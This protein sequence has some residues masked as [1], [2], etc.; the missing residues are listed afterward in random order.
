LSAVE[1]PQE[2]PTAGGG[3]SGVP[4]TLQGVAATGL[5]TLRARVEETHRRDALFEDPVGVRM[6]ERL[7][8]ASDAASIDWLTQAGVAL[9]TEIFDQAVRGFLRARPHAVVANLGAGFCTRFHRVDDGMVRWIDVDLPQVI[10]LKR[11]VLE[12][13]A[14]YRLVASSLTDPAWMDCVERH[15]GQAMLVVAEGVL[16]YLKERDVRVLFERLVARFS[17][18]EMVFDC[19][20]P[21]AVRLSGLL[22]SLARTGQRPAWGLASTRMLR[23]LHPDIHLLAGWSY[24]RHPDRLRWIRYVRRVPAV[25]RLMT[26][27]HVRLG[28]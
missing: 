26:T 23:V 6:L 21:L 20:S 16:A 11:E 10:A 19:V 24:D 25:R 4:A 7:G 13:H 1:T 17:G 5:F 12:P 8:S 9:R 18:A 27:L 15:V 22:P 28:P 2:A 3:A 14:R